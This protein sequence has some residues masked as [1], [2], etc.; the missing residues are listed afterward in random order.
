MNSLCVMKCCFGVYFP[1]CCGNSGNKHQNNTQVSVQ[2]FIMTVDILSYFLHD[3]MRQEMMIKK[4]F[5]HIDSVSR[6]L[7]LHFADDFTVHYTMYNEKRLLWHENMKTEI[8]L[9][10]YCSY[11]WSF[12][13]LS[14]E[15][16]AY[17]KQHIMM[18]VDQCLQLKF[19]LNTPYF[20]HTK[21]L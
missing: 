4:Q 8:K 3:I 12:T 11:S 16:V 18:E 7:H 10:R 2:Q 17:C 6:S 5:P 15:K 19:T 14:S 1:S 9:I 20:T 21:K 13:R